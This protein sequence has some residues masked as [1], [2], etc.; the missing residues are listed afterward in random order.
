M[1]SFYE[2]ISLD[3][4]VVKFSNLAIEAASMIA[5]GSSTPSPVNTQDFWARL[6][7]S[8]VALGRFEDAHMILTATPYRES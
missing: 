2:A 4:S 8:T 5:V 3:A 6:F 7:K 1:I